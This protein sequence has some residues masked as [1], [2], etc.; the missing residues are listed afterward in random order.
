[1]IKKLPSA[2]C[3]QLK[4]SKM[5]I[6]FYS[7]LVTTRNMIKRIKRVKRCNVLLHLVFGRYNPLE[8]FIFHIINTKNFRIKF[9][10]VGLDASMQYLLHHTRI[11]VEIQQ[12]I[13]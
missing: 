10:L 8:N 12:L 13:E 1:M 5:I 4:I 7:F 11:V 3:L 9:N 6:Q 2:E